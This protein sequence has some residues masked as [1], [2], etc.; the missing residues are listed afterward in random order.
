MQ[1]NPARGKA[2]VARGANPAQAELPSQSICVTPVSRNGVRAEYTNSFIGLTR[3]QIAA[4]HIG[5]R[6]Q[7]VSL[8]CQ[9]KTSSTLR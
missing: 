9:T 4:S 3:R 5:E 8:Q 1:V 7:L 2:S 6:N